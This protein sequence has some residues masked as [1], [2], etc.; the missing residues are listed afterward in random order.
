MVRYPKYL[1]RCNATSW[2]EGIC[3]SCEIGLKQK[4]MYLMEKLCVLPNSLSSKM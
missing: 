2:E 3:I 1:H 4:K